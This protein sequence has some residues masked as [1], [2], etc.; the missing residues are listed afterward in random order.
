[1]SKNKLGAFLFLF[2][3]LFYLY[4][5]YQIP[6][7]PG[8]EFEVMTPKTFPLALAYVSIAV[9][10]LFI[11][12]PEK[13]EKGSLL[14]IESLKE[15]DFKDSIIL[16]V[17]MFAYGLTIRNIGF[18]ISTTLFLGIG[19]YI[20]K[21]RRLKMLI[22]LPLVLTVSFWLLLTQGLGI[23]IEPGQLFDFVAGGA[24]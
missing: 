17:L 4:E 11:I 3:S 22:I 14:T 23:Y 20:L 13:I 10:L 18:I 7:L 9:S 1:M 19:F 16:V 15:L 24:S 6:N 21:E 12:L 2:F 5:A 8:M